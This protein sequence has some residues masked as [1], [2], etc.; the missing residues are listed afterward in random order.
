MYVAFFFFP[1]YLLTHL[2]ASYKVPKISSRTLKCK[3]DQNANLVVRQSDLEHA[4][5][6]RTIFYKT[7][8]FF[9]K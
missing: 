9:P 2:D 6:T 5:S 1:K 4:F 8:N 7:I 3:K